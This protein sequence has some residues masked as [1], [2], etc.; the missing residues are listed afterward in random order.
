M[1]TQYLYEFTWIIYIYW[2][3][4]VFT[5]RI[6]TKILVH[7]NYIFR[8]IIRILL[9]QY[10]VSTNIHILYNKDYLLYIITLCKCSCCINFYSALYSHHGAFVF[11]FCRYTYGKP[12]TGTVKLRAK[13]DY[14]YHAWNYHGSEPMVELSLNVSSTCNM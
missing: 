11:L 1:K 12:V 2:E 5:I 14:F 9:P 3:K 7:T 8:I 4:I 10:E 6:K 13:L